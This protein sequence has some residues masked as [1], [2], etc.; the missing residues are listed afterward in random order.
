MYMAWVWPDL[1]KLMFEKLAIDRK[2]INPPIKWLQMIHVWAKFLVD[3]CQSTELRYG[4]L[5]EF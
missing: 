5:V 4:N 3:Q 2:I 1:L